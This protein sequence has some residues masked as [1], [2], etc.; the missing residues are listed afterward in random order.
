MARGHAL[1]HGG[2][3]AARA[4]VGVL[5]SLLLHLADQAGAVV[6]EVVLEITHEQ[7]LG[8]AGAQPGQA[9]ELSHL[10]YLGLLEL[11]AV[12][13]QVALTVIQ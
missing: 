6:A 2:E 8:L 13:L 7:L 5:S 12:A 3:D 9:L 4:A 10:A 1:H 11:L